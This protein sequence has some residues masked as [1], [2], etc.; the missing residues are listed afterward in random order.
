MSDGRW[1]QELTKFDLPR[2]MEAPKIGG[3]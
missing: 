2:G 1:C 3:G